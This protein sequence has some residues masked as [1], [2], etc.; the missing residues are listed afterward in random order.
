MEK[1]YTMTQLQ[2]NLQTTKVTLYNYIKSGRLKAFK[3]G[4]TWRVTE[5]ALQEFINEST[6]K[7]EG[8]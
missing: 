8:K 2:E 3:V 6:H 1:V 4:R 7:G 5:S